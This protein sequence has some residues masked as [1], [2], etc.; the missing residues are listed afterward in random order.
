ME[1]HE[2]LEEMR[3]EA[4][5]ERERHSRESTFR[6]RAAIV[7]AV[8]AALLALT[9]VLSDIA[10]KN[11]V[12]ANVDVADTRSTIDARKTDLN[13]QRLALGNMQEQ[14]ADPS[15]APARRALIQQHMQEEQALIAKT[16]SSPDTGDGIKELQ[17]LVD[18]DEGTQRSSEARADSYHIAEV[19]LQIAIVLASVAI[20]ILSFPILAVSILAGV[21]GLLMVL[22]G[23][24][25]VLHP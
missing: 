25:L 23:T 10:V 6:S 3:A 2:A 22:N 14:L 7:I 11:E 15:I 8:M 1:A 12:N 4:I 16:Q 17:A 24:L 9:T 20:L 18:R 13:A 5:G 21:A 19:L